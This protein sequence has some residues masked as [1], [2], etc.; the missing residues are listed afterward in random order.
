MLPGGFELNLLQHSSSGCM[1]WEKRHNAAVTAYVKAALV[2][3]RVTARLHCA[4]DGVYNI[5]HRYENNALAFA[6]VDK[7]VYVDPTIWE[8]TAVRLDTY[9]LRS[10]IGRLEPHNSKTA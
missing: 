5:Q 9:N 6:E 7:E 10:H 4:S 1:G 2:T 8:S 3:A